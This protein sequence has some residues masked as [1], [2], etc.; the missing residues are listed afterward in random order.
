MNE[1]RKE[2]SEYTLWGMAPLSL[3]ASEQQWQL[4][5]VKE[6]KSITLFDYIG[7][8]D[9]IGKMV[10]DLNQRDQRPKEPTVKPFTVF[11]RHQ[12]G[13]GFERKFECYA[14]NE[15]KAT[16]QFRQRYG[17]NEIRIMR[18]QEGK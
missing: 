16:S 18:I 1:L 10:I 3:D 11:Y 17:Y 9:E 15:T 6:D 12:N 7:R 8:M 4:V 2:Q 5:G 13:F 14:E